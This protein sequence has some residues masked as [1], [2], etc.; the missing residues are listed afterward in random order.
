MP[1]APPPPTPAPYLASFRFQVRFTQNVAL[2][3]ANRSD[4]VDAAFAE[5]SGLEA[6]IE[7]KTH[8]EGGRA[9]GVRQLV[10][11]VTYPN[12][13]LKRGLG[14]N[15]EAWRWF[16]NVARGVRPVPRKNVMIELLDKDFTTVIA[17]WNVSRAV[18]VKMKVSD[19]N[20]KTGEIAIEEIHLAHEG[21]EMDFTVGG[22]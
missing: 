13:V 6:N 15:A 9:Q 22:R 16:T 17:R 20:A 10:G 12:I 14:R 18:P 1:A 8:A 4:M 7:I 11:R 21:L 2:T 19:L 3:S 5:V